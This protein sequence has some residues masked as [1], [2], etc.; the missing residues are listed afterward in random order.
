MTIAALFPGQ[1]SQ[2]VGMG[3]DLYENFSYVKELFEEVND[4]LKRD[5][6]K[7][8]EEGPEDQLTLTENT[9]P[10]LMAT[11]IAALKVLE[12]EGG[13]DL[14]HISYFAGHSLGEYTALVA[15]GALT[16][17]DGTRLLD[18]R[19]KS[20]QEAVPVG[21]GA[22]AAILGMDFER[23]K[24]VV[25]RASTEDDF[26]VCANDNAE[27]QVVISGHKGAVERAIEIAKEMGVKRAVLLP[28]SAPFHCPLMKH[29]EQ[30]MA[31]ALSTVEIS[32][33]SAPIIANVMAE[34]VTDPHVI[35]QCLIDQ[36]CGSVRWRESMML[37]SRRN[38]SKV[39]EVGAG[40]VLA[41]LMKRID[42]NIPAVSLL[43]LESIEGYIKTL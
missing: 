17:S 7:V 6:W 38:V 29:A 37:L 23:L 25:Q 15:A 41:G 34:E 8:I 20:M 28:V 26:C 42:S 19:G 16:L 24:D 2:F 5:L 32:V 35:R 21:V 40:K 1:G 43:S 3:K 10:A 14:G 33:P 39:V 30:K 9:Q 4:V 18:I 36:V 27:G 13:F 31:E 22:M 11:S 12:K